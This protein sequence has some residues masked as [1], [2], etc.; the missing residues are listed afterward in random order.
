MIQKVLN[1]YVI[2]TVSPIS[3][4]TNLPICKF[5]CH[6]KFLEETYQDKGYGCC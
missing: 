6:E 4:Y 5:V 3:L 1:K 2:I